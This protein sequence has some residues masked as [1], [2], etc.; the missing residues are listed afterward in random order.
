MKKVE[1]IIRHFKL[2][3]V[4]NALSEQGI[5]GMTDHMRIQVTS[6]SGIALQCL[7][8]GLPD[9]FSV[10]GGLLVTLDH[11]YLQLTF[12]ISDSPGQQGR[13]S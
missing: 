4:K 12:K 1:A 6:L 5:Q 10:M 9:T 2:E 7:D 8:T 3:D 13:F 11:R